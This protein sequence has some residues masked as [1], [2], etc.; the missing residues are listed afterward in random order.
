MIY[1]Q[2][3]IYTALI[4]IFT[5]NITYENTAGASKLLTFDDLKHFIQFYESSNGKYK[6]NKTN[7]N[8]TVDCGLYQINSSHFN[9]TGKRTDPVTHGF[10]SIFALNKVS[11]K[12]SERI[13]ETIRNDSLCGQLAEFL[14]NE[15]GIQEWVVYSKF[16]QYLEGYRYHVSVPTLQR[17][18][19]GDRISTNKRKVQT[20][21]RANSAKVLGHNSTSTI[22]NTSPNRKS[23][24]TSRIKVL[25]K[26]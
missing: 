25:S 8:G 3:L 7:K 4:L 24:S 2:R 9:P 14:Y 22:R 1:A 16:K 6:F 18:S 20:S 12:V 5:Y 11:K 10:D 21:V 17:K 19:N 13:V 15:R 26:D 23:Y